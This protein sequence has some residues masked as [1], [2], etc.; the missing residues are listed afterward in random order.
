MEMFKYAPTQFAFNPAIEVFARVPK[1]LV[2]HCANF[3][4]GWYPT[5]RDHLAT[6]QLQEDPEKVKAD[7]K[8]GKV[9]E[10]GLSALLAP[11]GSVSVPDTT[12]YVPLN[13]DMP[14][15]RQRGFI[16]LHR[17]KGFTQDLNFGLCG[18]MYR[19]HGKA[20]SVS[21][22]NPCKP[23][24]IFNRHKEPIFNNTTAGRNYLALGFVE[25]QRDGSAIVRMRAMID[26]SALLMMVHP[27][28]PELK[29]LT[30]MSGLPL[31]ARLQPKKIA[32]YLADQPGIKGV[33]SLPDPVRWGFLPRL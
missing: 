20:Y 15:D 21:P 13:Q 8:W 9:W 28:D 14:K 32:V 29:I 18:E 3:A 25:E 19:I 30:L 26:L 4:E 24:W 17:N 33:E 16:Y 7:H 27:D 23:S 2:Q 10:H 12:I 5:S 31:S 6:D 1:E 22:D 11:F